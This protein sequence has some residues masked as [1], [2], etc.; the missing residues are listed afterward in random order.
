MLGRIPLP[1]RMQRIILGVLLMI[2]TVIG[3]VESA[4]WKKWIALGL[5]MELVLTGLAGWCPIYWACNVS[6][7]SPNGLHHHETKRS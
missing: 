5:Q 1:G 3:I 2:L 4:E 6:N 7:R